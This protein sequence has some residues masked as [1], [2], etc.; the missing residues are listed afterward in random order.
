MVCQQ[1]AQSEQLTVSE[2][3]F[4]EI[5]QLF[6]I[7]LTTFFLI[8]QSCRNEKLNFQTLYTQGIFLPSNNSLACR[9]LK[10][11]LLTT[12]FIYTLLL[13]QDY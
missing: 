2:R 13:R 8:E 7:S 9:F 11:I 5:R 4:P 10:F 3:S 12:S 1:I 6:V